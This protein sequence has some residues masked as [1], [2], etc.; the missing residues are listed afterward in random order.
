MRIKKK[1]NKQNKKKFPRFFMRPTE[2]WYYNLTNTHL[3]YLNKNSK[4]NVSKHS[5]G[6]E[7]THTHTHHGPVGLVELQNKA[8][9]EFL[10]M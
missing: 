5:L 3:G 8:T 1:K 4:Q 7:R 10:L 2:S 6:H 9:S